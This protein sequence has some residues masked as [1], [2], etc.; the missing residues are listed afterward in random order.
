MEAR[1]REVVRAAFG[2][3]RK[4]L[5]NALSEGLR[6]PLERARE[7]TAQAGLDPARRAETLTIEEF[8]ALTAR[9]S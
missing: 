9:L 6:L 5:P 8:V 7:A 4:T 1:F 2:R 3:R